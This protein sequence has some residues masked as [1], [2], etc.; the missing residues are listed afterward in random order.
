[1]VSF[2]QVTAHRVVPVVVLKDPRDASP[3]AAALVAG[4]LPVAELTL[5]TPG[6]LDAIRTMAARGDLIVGAGT[7]LTVHQVDEAVDAGAQFVVSPGLSDAVVERC[8]Q[9]EVL[10]LPGV[11]TATEL[12]RAV[13]LGLDAVKFFPASTNGGHLAVA[14]LSA[15]FAGVRFMPTGGISATDLSDY[16]AVPAVAAVGGSWMVPTEE[17]AAQRFDVVRDLVSGAVAL[18]ADAA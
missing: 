17:I 7:V 16:L 10:S 14:A 5:R 8:R 6:A 4:G 1:M 11:V 18:A 2:E 15:P 13:E 12:L 9:R 3:L